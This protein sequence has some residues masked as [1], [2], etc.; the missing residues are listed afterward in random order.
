M[1]KYLKPK[2]H[3]I[4][5]REYLLFKLKTVILSIFPRAEVVVFG[6][7]ATGMFLPDRYIDNKRET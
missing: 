1:L 6:S 5:L 2:P 7:H 3:E 4:R